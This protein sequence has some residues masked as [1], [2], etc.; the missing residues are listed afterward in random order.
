SLHTATVSKFEGVISRILEVAEIAREWAET[1]EQKRNSDI[2]IEK[3]KK[4]KTG[5]MPFTLI[6]ED[7]FGNSM[8]VA[9]NQSEV[10]IKELTVEELRDLR[11]G[12]LMFFTPSDS[13]ESTQED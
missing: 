3:I 5:E 10:K 6:L 7:P 12:G 8:I 2:A 13:N 1:E 9:K 11:T 4:A